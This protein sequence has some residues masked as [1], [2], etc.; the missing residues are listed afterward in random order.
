[1]LANPCLSPQPNHQKFWP[2]LQH[3]VVDTLSL[4]RPIQV[5]LQIGET[6][7]TTCCIRVLPYTFKLRCTASRKWFA[8]RCGIANY[9]I[10]IN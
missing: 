8:V 2:N 5:V 6:V 10:V 1:M 3:P 7:I 4:K 9:T